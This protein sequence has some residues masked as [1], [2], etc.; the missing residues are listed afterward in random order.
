ME[1]RRCGC[2]VSRDT[3]GNGEARITYCR[4]HAVAPEMLEALRELLE[5][6]E[7][8]NPGAAAGDAFVA[9]LCDNAR[10]AIAKAEGGRDEL[11]NR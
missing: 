7:D 9:M 8:D 4:L 2:Y 10:A 11:Q 3:W 6:V 1:V 5:Y